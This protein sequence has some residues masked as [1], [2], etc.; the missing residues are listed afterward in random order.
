MSLEILTLCTKVKQYLVINKKLSRSGSECISACRSWR[1]QASIS[2]TRGRLA[3]PM[4]AESDIVWGKMHGK[5]IGTQ[6]VTRPQAYYDITG[7]YWHI[8]PGLAN[9][10]S[11]WFCYRIGRNCCCRPMP[12]SE[13]LCCP[14]FPLGA[15][16]YEWGAQDWG[17]LRVTSAA[18]VLS[19]CL[20]D[21]VWRPF[22]VQYVALH[23]QGVATGQCDS[24]LE[25]LVLDY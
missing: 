9:K 13:V 25:S 12:T 4:N 15:R 21:L 19:S 8:P 24:K 14:W 1:I 18:C 22:G 2:S 6:F 17:C 23:H 10:C 16:L 3:P 5:E 11:H 20:V 7:I